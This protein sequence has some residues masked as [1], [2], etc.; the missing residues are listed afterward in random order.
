M[1]RGFGCGRVRLHSIIIGGIMLASCGA[2]QDEADR[3]LT[4]EEVESRI[5]RAI[6]DGE[7]L[8]PGRWETRISFV[9]IP[10]LSA[11]MVEARNRAMGNDA[12]ATCL[13]AEQA[14]R[15]DARF[16]TGDDQDCTYRSFELEG[17]RID[18]RLTC[19][20]QGL[21]MET[22]LSGEYGPERYAVDMEM[23]NDTFGEQAMTLRIEANRA[24]DCFPAPVETPD[25][26]QGEG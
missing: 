10:G 7:F 16:I 5:D 20:V 19:S 6:A 21:A 15:S 3:I 8:A 25:T 24:G 14:E 22:H 12:S 26:P 2:P 23:R 1:K 17:G 4:E 11:N 9:S 13:A 18:A